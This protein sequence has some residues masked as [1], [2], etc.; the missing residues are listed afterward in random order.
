[1]ATNQEKQLE[2]L[3][4]QL[5]AQAARHCVTHTL[6]F[7]REHR[8]ASTRQE[9]LAILRCRRYREGRVAGSVFDLVQQKL[10]CESEIEQGLRR[11]KKEGLSF[12]DAY[13]RLDIGALD[14]G[15]YA[16]LK[17]SYERF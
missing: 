1:M 10:D 7:A 8:L 12:R 14:Q 11:A 16:R 13:Y 6:E 2:A 3:L 17:K 4:P 15:E 5:F 9:L